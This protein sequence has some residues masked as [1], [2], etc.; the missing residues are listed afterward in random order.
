MG[1]TEEF[2]SLVENKEYD[3]ALG[4]LIQNQ[5][6]FEP[7]VFYYNKGTLEARRGDLVSARVSFEKAKANNYLTEELIKN[8]EMTKDNLGVGYLEE[9]YSLEADLI[10][11][12]IDMNI[13]TPIILTSVLLSTFFYFFKEVK[14]LFLIALFFVISSLPVISYYY[15]N[16]NY[17]RVIVQEEAIVRR[18]PSEIFEEQQIIPPG[19]KV[20][21]KKNKSEWSHIFLPRSHAGWITKTKMEKL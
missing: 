11:T 19:M 8:L 21:L 10:N 9:T 17:E 15:F 20:I 14:N 12:V 4:F 3:R 6:E 7:G 5:K 18:G 13:Y 1:I 16:E 2:K